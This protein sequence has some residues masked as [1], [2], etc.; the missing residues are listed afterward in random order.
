MGV[1][2]PPGAHFSGPLAQLVERLPL[3]EIVRGSSPRWLTEFGII[4]VKMAQ[5]EAL[6]RS[7]RQFYDA[8]EQATYQAVR[9]PKEL[10]PSVVCRSE[11]CGWAYTYK[12]DGR[13]K[14]SRRMAKHTARTGHEKF[15]LPS[16]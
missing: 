16:K 1:R 3:K 12:L 11:D 10:G 13:G 8:V 4:K 15:I 9:N 5:I 2:F 7:F 14:P 6:T